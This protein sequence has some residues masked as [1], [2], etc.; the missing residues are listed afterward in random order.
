[1]TDLEHL[2]ITVVLFFLVLGTL[3]LVH[4]LGHFLSAKALEVRVLEFGIGFPPRARVLRSTGET[5]WTLN[6]LPLGG[7][8]KL[9]GEDGDHSEDRG[10][11]AGRWLPTQVGILVAGVVMNVVLGFV[12]FVLIAWQLSPVFG[13]VVPQNGVQPGSPAEQAGLVGGDILIGVNG[14]RFDIFADADILTT[15]RNDIG[16]TIQLEVQH[17]D[18]SDVTIPVTL[19]S[20]SQVDD[21]HGP[22]GIFVPAGSGSSFE[23]VPTTFT[24]T[25]PLG[26]AIGLGAAETARAGGLIVGALGGLVAGF[27]TNPTAP[28]A[29]SGPIGIAYEIGQVFFSSGWAGLLF[30]AG[31]LSVNLAVVNILPFPPLDGG[32][33]LVLV[34]KRLARGQ[35]SLRAEQL[36]YLVGFVFLFAFILWISGFDVARGLGLTQ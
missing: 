19:R 6:W 10:S 22:L 31:L 32:R 26:E 29:A 20:A 15:I 21:S 17:A 4:E 33:I 12:L 1:M 18:G 25:H 5:L 8:V 34:I 13:V 14:R 16:Q 3:V 27:A 9:D 28:P 24:G 36:T 2:V 11:F 23:A 35:M 30:L 7:F